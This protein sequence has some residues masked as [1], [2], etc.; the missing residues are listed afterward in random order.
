MSETESK[1]WTRVLG[2]LAEHG[3]SY[4]GDSRAVVAIEAWA[5]A[6]RLA[7]F[8]TLVGVTAAADG[9][10]AALRG[11]AVAKC[12]R[13][14]GTSK[15]EVIESCIGME[16]RRGKSRMRPWSDYDVKRLCFAC[17]AYWHAQMLSDTLERMKPLD[18]ETPGK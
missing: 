17:R 10:A 5:E 3:A 13:L 18:A 11:E 1:A 16:R 14:T 12:S 15:D 6:K 2:I 7:G 4:D 9:M 8:D